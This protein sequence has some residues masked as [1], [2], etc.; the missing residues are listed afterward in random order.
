MQSTFNNVV[1]VILENSKTH[2]ATMNFDWLWYFCWCVESCTLCQINVFIMSLMY[3]VL[4][5]NFNQGRERDNKNIM[6][7]HHTNGSLRPKDPKSQKFMKKGGSIFFFLHLGGKLFL[8]KEAWHLTY[9]LN[10]VL[11]PHKFRKSKLF[12]YFWSCIQIGMAFEKLK[13]KR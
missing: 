4:Y 2:K 13:L 9:F 11:V 10:M 6:L 8:R 3:D 1:I 5:L 7:F 12:H